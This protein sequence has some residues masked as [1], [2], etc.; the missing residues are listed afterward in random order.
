M[1]GTGSSYGWIWEG[2]CIY[3]PYCF[4]G[5][6]GGVAETILVPHLLPIPHFNLLIYINAIDY[7]I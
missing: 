6:G 7:I 2:C 4:G 3:F 5:G 1:K